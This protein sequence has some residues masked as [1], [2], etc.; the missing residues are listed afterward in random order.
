MTKHY[1]SL[2]RF[3]LRLE[4]Q[5]KTPPLPAAADH[6]SPRSWG[7]CARLTQSRGCRVSSQ[8]RPPAPGASQRPFTWLHSSLGT[9]DEAHGLRG[10]HTRQFRSGGC[11]SQVQVWPGLLPSRAAPLGCGQSSPRVSP[12]GILSVGPESKFSLFKEPP[13]PLG[14]SPPP[15]T[16][17]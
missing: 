11:R 13:V 17:S 10:S 4:G 6:P 8:C 7:T 2:G 1:T 14:E 12:R 3:L 16:P 9:G 15:V 5:G